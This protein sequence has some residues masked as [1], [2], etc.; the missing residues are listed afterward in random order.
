MKATT[1]TTTGTAVQHLA[2]AGACCGRA[3][4][5]LVEQSDP[6]AARE[7]IA[8]AMRSIASALTAIDAGNIA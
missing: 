5:E 3:T 8:D 6:R 2:E 1:T 4:S 7:Y